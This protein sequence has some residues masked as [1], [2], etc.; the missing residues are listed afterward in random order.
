MITDSQALFD[1]KQRAARQPQGRTVLDLEADSLHRH[2]EKLCLIQYADAEEGVCIIDPLAIEDMSLFTLWL[3]E[4]DVWMHGADYDM[5]LFQGAYGV[6]PHMILDTQ[7]AARLLGFRQFG[8][9]ALVEH[10]YGVVLSKK[11]QKADWGKRP[12]P[13][14]MQEYA[15]GDVKYMLEMAD[16]LVAG[17]QEKGRY[18][19]FLESCAAN[20][21]HGYERFHAANEEPWRIRGCGKFNR[22]G[23]AALR[24]LWTWRDREA[25]EIDRPC[26]MVC[27]NDDLLRWALAL[28][29]FRPVFPTRNMHSHRAA[30]FRKAVERFQLMDE[31]EY[32]RIPKHERHEP[33]P[34]FDTRLEHWQTKRNEL[35]A[36][37]DIDN[38]LIA[39]R[40]QLEAIATDE[41]SG[42]TKLMQWQRFLLLN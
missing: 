26:F 12:I 22:R 15:Q 14:A 37:L 16:K 19:W 13:P 30:R 17:L 36:E 5:S 9:A 38:A 25:A 40:A 42:L 34:H 6:L 27:N 8:L 29:E 41:A 2:R 33:D 39:S 7:I 32:P 24:T 1:W 11:N 3:Q 21:Q 10:Y 31:E 18:E 28:Q 4:A 35:A 23:L 20:L